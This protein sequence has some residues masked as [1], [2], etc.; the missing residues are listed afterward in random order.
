MIR[1]I[2]IKKQ[3]GV[4]IHKFGPK[5]RPISDCRKVFTVSEF[6]HLAILTFTKVT[7]DQLARD[8]GLD[9]RWRAEYGN[10]QYRDR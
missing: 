9:I 10:I 7:P 2:S 4:K 6:V 3:L 8:M 1:I 5:N